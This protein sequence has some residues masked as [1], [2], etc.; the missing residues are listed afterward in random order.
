MLS[1]SYYR[2]YY[3]A[4]QWYLIKNRKTSNGIDKVYLSCWRNRQRKKNQTYKCINK[5][6][7]ILYLLIRLILL[8]ISFNVIYLNKLIANNASSLIII[9]KFLFKNYEYFE[10]IYSPLSTQMT[11]E[12]SKSICTLILFAFLPIHFC[13]FL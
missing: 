3:N 12:S 10:L 8:C 1:L 9:F 7:V 13:P 2:A 4:W 6:P 5:R 11:S